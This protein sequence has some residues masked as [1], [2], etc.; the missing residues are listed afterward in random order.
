METKR[1]WAMVGAVYMIIITLLMT[2]W[3]SATSFITGIT[4][5]LLF[6]LCGGMAVQCFNNRWKLLHPSEDRKAPTG[7]PGI[8]L[9]LGIACAIATLYT[10]IT[11][12]GQ[13]MAFFA[14]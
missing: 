5:L 4:G 3:I 14:G 2:Y 12:I 7:N 8:Y 10:L 13:L 1:I 6:P 9:L 11:G